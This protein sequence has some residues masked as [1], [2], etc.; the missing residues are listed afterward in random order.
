MSRRFY[1]NITHELRTPLTLI[2]GPL[3]DMIEDK[4]L[5][6]VYKKRVKLIYSSAVRLLN[7]VNEILEFR[8]TETQNRKLA[9]ER[10]SLAG[11]VKEIGLRYK[12]LNHNP[13]V[14]YVIDVP[15]KTGNDMYFDSEVVT[16]ILNNL[17]SNAVKY[18]PKGHISL[19]LREEMEDGVTY[20]DI[21]VSDSGH[22]ISVEALPHIFTRYY[23]AEGKHQV[24]GTGIG[25]ALAKSLAYT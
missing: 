21:I 7:L 13:D 2:I 23:Q 22:G 3:E 19:S 25:L 17:L 4:K 14:K 11:V 10:G 24:P 8:K 1:T 18:T 15:D 12:E 16:T 20:A 5:P 6:A 9:V